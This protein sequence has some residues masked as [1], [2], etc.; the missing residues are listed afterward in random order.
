M[1]RIGKL[2]QLYETQRFRHM[3]TRSELPSCECHKGNRRFCHSVYDAHDVVTDCL[4]MRSSARHAAIMD[5][6]Q[7]NALGNALAILAVALFFLSLGLIS[8]T[9]PA[10]GLVALL[11]PAAAC[12]ITTAL[13]VAAL[14]LL[15]KPGQ[16]KG[17][18]GNILLRAKRALLIGLAGGCAIAVLSW[19]VILY[20]VVK[21]ALR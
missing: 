21:A 4:L 6:K 19:T 20:F 10:M 15:G 5:E 9:A 17:Q 8:Y 7:S 11:F 14:R 18:R 1:C 13:A 2:F 16:A 3:L 12:T